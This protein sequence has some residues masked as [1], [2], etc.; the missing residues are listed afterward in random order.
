M[1]YNNVLEKYNPKVSDTTSIT[2]AAV[3][4]W[5][6]INS[7]PVCINLFLNPRGNS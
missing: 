6:A 5:T 7:K 1:F 3:F 4:V 2:I